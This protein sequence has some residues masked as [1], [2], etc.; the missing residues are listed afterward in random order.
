MSRITDIV[1][2]VVALATLF[3]ADM[4]AGG[5]RYRGGCDNVGEAGC[6]THNE[7][8]VRNPITQVYS[9]D[10]GGVTAYSS[11]LSPMRYSGWGFALSG[12]WSKNLKQNPEKIQMTF[13][14][15]L[16]CSSLLNPAKSAGMLGASAYFGWGLAAQWH[17]ACR[18][19]FTLGGMF[20]LFGGALYLMRNSNNPVTP[21]AY[22]G[23][24]LTASASFRFRFGRLPV[25]VRDVVRIPSAG[26]FFSPQYGETMYEIYLGNRKDL[27][28]FG[29]WGNSF[30]IDNMLA[31]D[32]M[33][34]RKFLRL[35]YRLDLR[36]FNA[37][38]LDTQI[39]RNSFTIAYGF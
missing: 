6:C 12:E 33:F 5:R 30:G 3:P 10:T 36:T 31:F 34:G 9:L 25:V 23:I 37:E 19:H 27:V 28:H 20:D 4:S 32:L 26:A 22:A 38:N 1:G 17:P 35:G 29:W 14:A 18:W 21:L 15:K 16:D 11:Y 2:A 24:D 7:T 13:A 39:L 8:A